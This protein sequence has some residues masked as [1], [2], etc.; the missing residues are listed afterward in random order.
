MRCDENVCRSEN[1][2]KKKED[3]KLVKPHYK[4]IKIR[5]IFQ[6]NIVTRSHLHENPLKAFDF[7]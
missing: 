3:R 2:T 5:R 1:E 6:V 7:G 4:S